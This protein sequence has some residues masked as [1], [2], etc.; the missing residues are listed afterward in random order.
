[1]KSS[2]DRH[3]AIVLPFPPRR[4][5]IVV[6]ISAHDGRQPLGR[7]RPLMLRESD[8]ARLVEVAERMEGRAP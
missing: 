4:P 8:L 1:M 5:R 3:G 2:I 6:N 7:T